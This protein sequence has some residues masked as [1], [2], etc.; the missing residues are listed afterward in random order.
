M[1][2]PVSKLVDGFD[3][4]TLADVDVA[5]RR[6]KRCVSGRSLFRRYDALGGHLALA[7]DNFCVHDAADYDQD[8]EGP[9]VD[10]Q[11][12]GKDPNWSVFHFL[13]RPSAQ[14]CRQDV[15]AEAEQERDD[16]GQHRK[17]ADLTGLGEPFEEPVVVHDVKV[18]EWLIINTNMW[19]V[20]FKYARAMGSCCSTFG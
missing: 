11:A 3:A 8:S 4:D 5:E 10:R 15:D 19:K 20:F 16:G 1:T 14:K 2:P 9:D 13:M 6:R 17:V 7:P 18:P 12:G